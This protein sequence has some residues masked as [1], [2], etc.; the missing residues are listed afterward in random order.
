MFSRA[1][2]IKSFRPKSSPALCGP[3]IP[4]PP[5]EGHEVI[6]QPDELGGIF[7]RRH[8][9]GAIDKGCNAVLL[10]QLSKFIGFDLT[11]WLLYIEEQH[12]SGL[13]IDGAL[14]LFARFDFH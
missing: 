9:T 8:I 5:L 13:V 10:A 7:D 2:L 3:R 11:D 12:H 1:A 6:T 14:E 4:L